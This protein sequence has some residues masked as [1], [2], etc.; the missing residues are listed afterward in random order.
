MTSNSS[1]GDQ[2]VWPPGFRFHPTD[3][4]LVLYYL[5]RKICRR[6]LKLDIIGETDVYKWDP[7]DL[8]GTDSLSFLFIYL[9]LFLRCLSIF[10]VDFN[11]SILYVFD[12]LSQLGF[13]FCLII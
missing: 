3:E 13:C 1:A 6:R 9:L 7:D 5:K 2:Q 12:C 10:F 4:E 8:P 11:F